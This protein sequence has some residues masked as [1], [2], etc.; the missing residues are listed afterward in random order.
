MHDTPN[1][2]TK[3]ASHLEYVI[4][5]DKQEVDKI[6]QKAFQFMKQL[7]GWCSQEKASLLIDL[8]IKAKPDTV[9]EIGV[10]GGKSL[11]PMGYALKAL[12]KGK[13]YGIDPWDSQA[14]IQGMTDE[15]NKKWWQSIDHDAIRRGLVSKISLFDVEKQIELIQST[16]EDAPPIYDIDILH[17]D[18]NHSEE[19]S[20]L[21][22][23]KWVPLVKSGGWIILDDLTWYENG[24]YTHECTI[25]WLNTNC[26]K[27][28]EFTDQC[29]W[30]IWIKP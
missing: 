17:I 13:I 23:T 27:F 28:A 15:V 9:V 8:I 2:D 14:S 11:I 5:I 20:F 6:K 30:G 22:V 26:I 21:D 4:D 24:K 1:A 29:V 18:G 7:E 19:A 25:E 12:K 3:P 10:F 16:S